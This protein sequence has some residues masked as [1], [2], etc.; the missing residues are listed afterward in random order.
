MQR[1]RHVERSEM[2]DLIVKLSQNS[3]DAVRREELAALF[4]RELSGT[5][6]QV[7][8]SQNG[9]GVKLN[10][11]GSGMSTDF[12]SLWSAVLE[13][14]GNR[15]KAE[16]QEKAEEQA[17]SSVSATLAGDDS[18]GSSSSEA[19]GEVNSVMSSSEGKQLWALIDMMVQSKVILKQYEKEQKSVN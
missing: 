5:T 2:E 18:T 1:K 12:V 10:G 15:V 9:A 3:N 7:D 8:K 17:R 14:V 16:A 6:G 11:A 4:S 19:A 13:T